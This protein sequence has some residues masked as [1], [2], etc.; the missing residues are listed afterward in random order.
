MKTTFS[1]KNYLL[2]VCLLLVLLISNSLSTEAQSNKKKKLYT[3]TITDRNGEIYKGKLHY[4]SDSLVVLKNSNTAQFTTVKTPDIYRMRVKTTS[5][6]NLTGIAL[7]GLEAVPAA[8]FI[9]Y[10]SHNS[11]EYMILPIVAGITA[12]I[13]SPVVGGIMYLGSG[14]TYKPSYG[15][16]GIDRLKPYAFTDSLDVKIPSSVQNLTADSIENKIQNKTKDSASDTLELNFSDKN[17]NLMPKSTSSES[18][19]FVGLRYGRPKTLNT[20]ASTNY[21]NLYNSQ[22]Y[23]EKN[24]FTAELLLSYKFSNTWHFG[25]SFSNRNKEIRVQGIKPGNWQNELSYISSLNLKSFEITNTFSLYNKNHNFGKAE[26]FSVTAGA[27]FSFNKGISYFQRDIFNADVPI[28]NYAYS[29]GA[30]AG[31][32]YNYQ[33]RDF[34]I[35]SI[36]DKLS[37]YNQNRFSNIAISHPEELTEFKLQDKKFY[38]LDNYFYLGLKVKF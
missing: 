5:Y 10:L 8:I 33:F 15:K 28:V 24:N 17:D 9:D 4:I 31:L 3:T 13:I 12:A 23:S 30:V 37:Y 16:P 22:Y 18:N 7:V 32:E 36:G 21:F 19:F 26:E 6:L 14:K 29:Y 11:S 35:V 2:Y 20:K 38:S 1:F 25:F 27:L 34:F